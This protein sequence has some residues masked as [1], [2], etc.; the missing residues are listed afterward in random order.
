MTRDVW[1]GRLV[2]SG[3][4]STYD[5]PSAERRK[6]HERDFEYLLGKCLEQIMGVG[7]FVYKKIEEINRKVD[8]IMITL[9]NLENAL[10]QIE[11]TDSEINT[12]VHSA[13]ERF[14]ELIAELEN[15][16][17]GGG[18]VTQAQVDV[19]TSRA[20]AVEGSLTAAATTLAADTPAKKEGSE[21][22][23]VKGPTLYAFTPGPS[24]ENTADSRFAAS[25]MREAEGAKDALFTFSGDTAPGETNG[26]AIAGYSV[27][28][29]PTEAVPPTA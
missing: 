27:F 28:T 23:G 26:A 10:S 19:I 24:N 11:I 17:T 25:G 7:M 9:E 4:M 2:V 5:P 20:Q 3:R 18:S 22:E 14:K 1:P 8:A 16:P 6:K 12:N 21:G 29:G 15:L 13:G